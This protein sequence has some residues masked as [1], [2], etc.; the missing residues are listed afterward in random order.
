VGDRS[1]TLRGL[2]LR[3]CALASSVN[4]GYFIGGSLKN[5]IIGPD[6]RETGYQL[7]GK[8]VDSIVDSRGH[9]TG[10]YVGGP[11][12]NTICR[13]DHG[14]TGYFIAGNGCMEIYGPS[15]ELP[16]A[17]KTVSNNSVRK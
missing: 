2:L 7:C 3:R 16:W 8:L 5:I 14:A 17:N 13:I 9:E 12:G 6:G 4:T 11:N 10:F 1:K 15:K